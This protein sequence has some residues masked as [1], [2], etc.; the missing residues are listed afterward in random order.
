MPLVIWSKYK[1][2]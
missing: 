1:Q 2:P